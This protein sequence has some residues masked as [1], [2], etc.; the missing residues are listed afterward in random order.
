MV[1]LCLVIQKAGC[2]TDPDLTSNLEKLGSKPVFANGIAQVCGLLS[3]MR[4]DALIIDDDDQH[5]DVVRTLASL[6]QFDLPI[7]LLRRA[8][9]ERQ[10][11]DLMEAGATEV[12][13]R[14][15][16]ARL[17]ALKVVKL[18]R[19]TRAMKPKRQAATL[20]V[21]SMKLNPREM[22][23]TVGEFS[24]ALTGKQFDLLFA[25]AARAGQLV[26]RSVLESAVSRGYDDS[27]RSI[28][29]QISRIR[30]CLRDIG[31]SSI[32]IHSVYGYGYCLAIV[33]DE[34]AQAEEALS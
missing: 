3:Q 5:A 12:I 24:L 15:A 23:A 10:E 7:L 16:S 1:S 30:K 8:F 34:A 33:V 28:D 26:H 14:T 22:L 19:S 6:A 4:F 21:G 18:A 20:G 27:G 13:A 32:H 31:D 2:P 17:V 11:I 25:L 9:S 29:M